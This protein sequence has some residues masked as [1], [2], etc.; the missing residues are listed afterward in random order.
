MSYRTLVNILL[1]LIFAFP[2]SVQYLNLY[3]FPG[4]DSLYNW[5]IRLLVFICLYLVAKTHKV[6]IDKH[7]LPIIVI[8][9]VYMIFVMIHLFENTIPMNKMLAVS[10]DWYSF[11]LIFFTLTLLMLLSRTF[12]DYVN[13][14]QLCRCVLCMNTFFLVLYAFRVNI[15]LYSIYDSAEDFYASNLIS[16]FIIDTYASWTIF[17]SIYI[18]K[19]EKNQ[20]FFVLSWIAILASLI[21]IFICNKRGP[22]IYTGI[23]I[24]SFWYMTK[25][26]SL[27]AIMFFLLVV[28]VFNSALGYL[29]DLLN[30]DVFKRFTMIESD[31]AS[32]RVGEFSLYSYSIEQILDSPILGSHFRILS[33]PFRGMYPHNFFLEI[34]MNFGI[35]LSLLFTL[36]VL[37]I[38]K[39]SIRIIKLEPNSLFFPLVL[40]YSF[41]LMQSTGTILFNIEF[42]LPLS[43]IASNNFYK[44]N[45]K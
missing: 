30:I 9:L 15:L 29:T 28:L 13:Y 2:F 20:L 44:I 17:A 27:K 5:T 26:F 1:I 42:W 37:K 6:L 34:A 38:I 35:F 11:L 41:L 45:N 4:L 10:P 39:K 24:A 16:P 7:N 18:L 36:L 8:F 19:N 40:L 43:M 23:V 22:M 3:V 12:N 33:Y 32:G 14:Q 31:G 25:R 21:L